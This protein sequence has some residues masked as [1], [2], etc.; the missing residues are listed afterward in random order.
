[1]AGQNPYPSESVDEDSSSSFSE[2]SNLAMTVHAALDHL[3]PEHRA[4][5]V[6]KYLFDYTERDIA[7]ILD[8]RTGTVKSRIFYARKALAKELNREELPL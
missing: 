3:S 2:Q 6:L 5:L 8:I 1:M 4:V 7:K